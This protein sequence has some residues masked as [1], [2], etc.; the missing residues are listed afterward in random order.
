MKKQPRHS[1]RRLPRLFVLEYP[2]LFAETKF[3]DD[4]TIALDVLLFEVSKETATLTYE[5]NQ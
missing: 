3:L 4:C 2:K 1:R 5:L